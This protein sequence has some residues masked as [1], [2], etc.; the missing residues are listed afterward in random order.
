MDKKCCFINIPITNGNNIYDY[1]KLLPIAD[2][3]SN[4]NNDIILENHQRLKVLESKYDLKDK[5]VFIF[6]LIR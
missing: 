2:G 1:L 5:F 4:T 6:L 3:D